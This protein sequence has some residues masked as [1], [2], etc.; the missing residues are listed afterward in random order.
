LPV[1]AFWVQDWIGVNV[2]PFGKQV[3]WNWVLDE[4]Y[5]TD[6]PQLQKTMQER[7]G[8]RTA[9]YV[10]PFLTNNPGYNQLYTEAAAHGY[11]V[12]N[13]QGEVYQILNG[14]FG[15]G[16]LDLSNPE[17]RTWIKQILKEN[18]VGIGATAW[19]A[20]FGEALPFNS[21]IH[22]GDPAV[23]HNRYPEE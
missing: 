11:L 23:W 12:E 21:V 6:W 3:Q 13:Q 22:S 1:A 17:T 10:N 2:T 9:V 5:Y 16:L 8:A 4:Q 14:D 18:V 7:L 15:A 20:D 19:M